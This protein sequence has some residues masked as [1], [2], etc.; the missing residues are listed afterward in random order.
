VK[1]NRPQ[2][3]AALPAATVI[4]AR[5]QESELQVLLLRRSTQSRFMGGNYVF[6]G[7][8]VEKVDE[9]LDWWQSHADLE[10]DLVSRRLGGDTT[11]GVPIAAAVAA[12]RETFEEAG[13]LLADHPA[14]ADG[15]LQK[16]CG[17]RLAKELAAD[18][19]QQLVQKEG[20]TIALSRLLRWSRWVT[21]A[22]M[23]FRY[24]TRFFVARMPED[25][26]CVPDRQEAVDALWVRPAEALERNL[27]GKIP[28]SPPTLITLHE[29]L[30]YAGLQLLEEAAAKRRWGSPL[31]PRWISDGS[32]MII[33]EPWDPEYQRPQIRIDAAALRA[34]IASVGEPFSRLWFSG[35]SWR[36]V[37]V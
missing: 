26:V 4:L 33:V 32:E 9:D 15:E 34:G 2:T 31:I 30:P 25:Q 22:G 17:R 1:R 14:A 28:L 6:P 11:G 19:L 16:V 12:I 27:T 18:W 7:G 10:P 8:V 23:R 37:A 36:P 35:E 29:M 20:W 24:D 3:V 21:P 5:E 13:V